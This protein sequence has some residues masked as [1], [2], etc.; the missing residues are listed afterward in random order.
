[1]NSKLQARL[2]ITINEK[3][4]QQATEKIE[5]RLSK[6]Y[7][8]NIDVDSKKT[9][10]SLKAQ[11]DKIKA[12]EI[13][14]KG[15]TMTA[16]KGI[17]DM[18]TRTQ[19]LVHWQAQLDKKQIGNADIF[20]GTSTNS[21]QVQADLNNVTKA[22]KEYEVAG[23]RATKSEVVQNM[24]KL[25]VSFKTAQTAIKQASGQTFSFGN[26]LE[27]AG[28]KFVAWMGITQVVL[29]TIRIIG[30]MVTSVVE[31]DTSLVE[32]QK[33]S[34]LAGESLDR[35]TERAFDSASELG[36]TGK[37]LVDATTNFQRSG[38][39]LEESF[40]L[41]KEA[42]LMLNIG[43]GIQD[44]DEATNTLISTLKAYN[45][46]VGESSK[47]NDVLNQ[48]SNTSAINFGTLAEGVRRTS[49]VFAQGNTSIEQLTGLLTGLNNC[50]I[51]IEICIKLCFNCR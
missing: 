22:M 23:T 33:V 15:M 28:K 48:V 50:P 29:G 8:I 19:K 42:L 32:L 10:S 14:Y 47:V 51:C 2:G 43:D 39:A 21:K 17:D 13:N 25:G 5:K 37:E 26:M 40:K 11:S 35:F 27:T 16:S 38:Y 9:E 36:R 4:L 49:A 20:G 41:G 3:E 7:K 18:I 34:D 1:M 12:L 44:V 45:I 46:E 31:L 24:D 6:N 30:Q